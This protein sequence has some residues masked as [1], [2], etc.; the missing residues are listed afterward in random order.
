M[1]KYSRSV[2]RCGPLTNA[3]APTGV[4]YC[5]ATSSFFIRVSLAGSLRQCTPVGAGGNGQ[6]S[7]A[8]SVGQVKLTRAGRRLT[9][10]AD[11]MHRP[12]C[13]RS[14]SQKG[15]RYRKFHPLGLR[16]QIGDEEW[17]LEF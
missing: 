17:V 9:P 13:Q 7:T 5:F 8:C 14:P 2:K 12:T 3:G 15:C 6:E 1:F 11:P 10:E 16:V 4:V